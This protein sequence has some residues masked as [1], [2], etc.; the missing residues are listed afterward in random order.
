MYFNG[1][2]NG[3]F[4]LLNKIKEMATSAGWEVLNEKS[5]PL[6]TI[7][8]NFE[9]CF[10]TDVQSGATLIDNSPTITNSEIY[11][12]LPRSLN[13]KSFEILGTRNSSKVQIYGVDSKNAE[14]LL[15]QDAATS[16]SV[17]GNKE[18][19]RFK[20]KADDIGEVKLKFDDKGILQSKELNLKSKGKSGNENIFLNLRA[21]L[22][23]PDLANLIIANALSYSNSLELK[24]QFGTPLNISTICGIDG[25]MEYFCNINKNRLIIALKIHKPDD[26]FQKDP[27]YQI[28]YFGKARIYGGE[29]SFCDPNVNASCS[30]DALC[31]WSACEKSSI[32]TP[33]AYLPKNGWVKFDTNCLGWNENNM[34]IAPYPSGELFATNITLFNK[35]TLL[36][37]LDGILKL[38]AVDGISSEDELNMDG[39]K[40]VVIG[41]G[42]KR[43]KFDFYAILKD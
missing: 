3:I 38:V 43:G 28:G 24:N 16:G 40:Y 34:N 33:L 41:D 35:T 12:T 17:N 4:E 10:I 23:A 26:A 27:V 6:D 2:V 7:P 9:G 42:K 32:D 21:F 13:L 22:A 14:F 30:T 18:F 20:I 15:I 36:G 29:W 11:I 39:E 1:K 8:P 19:N 5:A 37:E 31:R 25:E